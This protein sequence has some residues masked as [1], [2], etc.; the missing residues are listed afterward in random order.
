LDSAIADS[1]L[2]NRVYFSL[3][4]GLSPYFGLSDGLSERLIQKVKTPAAAAAAADDDDDNDV[5][6]GYCHHHCQPWRAYRHTA[7]RDSRE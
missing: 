6:A 5:S 4:F 1:K 7:R 2:K 3:I